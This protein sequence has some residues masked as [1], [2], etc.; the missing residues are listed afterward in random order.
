MP[1]TAQLVPTADVNTDRICQT[2]A[3]VTD[4]WDMLWAPHT[5]AHIRHHRPQ[6]HTPWR[7][8]CCFTRPDGFVSLTGC[9]MTTRSRREIDR[10]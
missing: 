10:R 4:I 1:F 5:N 2:G 6:R 7:L 9:S 8:P 3:Y